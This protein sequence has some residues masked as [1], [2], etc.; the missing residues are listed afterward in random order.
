MDYAV[1]VKGQEYQKSREID[2]LDTIRSKTVMIVTA[3]HITP[4][5][6]DLIDTLRGELSHR[7]SYRIAD[8]G[9][10]RKVIVR[11]GWLTAARITLFRNQVI[12]EKASR[13]NIFFSSVFMLLI[14]TPMPLKPIRAKIQDQLTALLK[15]KY[16]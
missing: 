14:S 10:G 13:I 8:S 2:Y 9:Q 11:Y 15:R 6:K 4:D 5:P 12:V 1:F 7:F 16:S 3:P